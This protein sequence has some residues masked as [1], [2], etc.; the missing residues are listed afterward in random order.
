VKQ[1]LG[2]DND[3]DN[4]P[5]IEQLQITGA[6][7][8]ITPLS[9]RAQRRLEERQSDSSPKKSAYALSISMKV[10]L[11]KRQLQEISDVL[12]FFFLNMGCQQYRSAFYLSDGLLDGPDRIDAC[13][14]SECSTCSICNGDWHKMHFPVYKSQLI[15]FFESSTGRKLLPLKIEGKT[16]LYTVHYLIFEAILERVDL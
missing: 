4:E 10:Q 13:Q 1:I 5:T 11:R 3:Q 16:T 12:R 14:E 6:G 2:Y 7:S 9:A 8:A 15:R